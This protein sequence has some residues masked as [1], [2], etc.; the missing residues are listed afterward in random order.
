MFSSTLQWFIHKGAGTWCL[1]HNIFCVPG[2]VQQRLFWDT[3]LNAK[4][5]RSCFSC[6][7][8]FKRRTNDIKREINTGM[9]PGEGPEG[10]GCMTSRLACVQTSS[11]SRWGR[12]G[13]E[14]AGECDIVRWC[15]PPGAS[16][17]CGGMTDAGT[18]FGVCVC[19]RLLHLIYALK[20]RASAAVSPRRNII[21]LRAF[22]FRV[23]LI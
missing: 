1:D 12:G 19:A 21:L 14:E 20:T 7:D 17:E 10:S 9:A 23:L 22:S 13:E 2:E 18:G 3:L 4:Q 8:T 5:S 16:H 11:G 15:R 6:S